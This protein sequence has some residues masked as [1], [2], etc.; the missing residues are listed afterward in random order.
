MTLKPANVGSSS[1][2]DLP[3]D[4]RRFELLQGGLDLIDQGLT[5]FDGDLRLVAWNL[6]FFTLLEFP[7]EMASVGRPFADFMRYNA[8]R[9]EYGDGDVEEK[10]AERVRLARAFQPH[11]MERVRPNGTIVAV[12]GEPLPYGGFVTIYT[13]IT[14]QRYHERLIQERN[15]ELDRRV[16]ERTAA[17]ET[18]NIDL[19]HAMAEQK[20]MQAALVQ[21]Q[22]MEAVGKLTGGLAHDFNNLLTIVIS[23]LAAIRDKGMAG[24]E[25]NDFLEP[26][27]AAARRG[28]DITRRLL[29]FA[30]QQPLEPRSVDVN[31]VV[32]NIL[33]LLRRSLP[34]IV[35]ITSEPG[36]GELH[37][38]ADPSQLENALVNLALNA[39][40]AM[41]KG[42]RLVM[43]TGRR[44]LS[45]TEAAELDVTPG[46]YVAIAVEDTGIGMDQATLS[47]VFEPFFTSKEFGSG[48][49]LGLSMVYGFVRQ[50]GGA[51]RM[52]SEPGKGTT[53]T[54]LL[55]EGVS[56]SD[57]AVEEAQEVLTGAT[58]RHAV[59]LVEDD[60][61]V[62]TVIRRQ[63]VDLGHSVIEASGGKEALAILESVPEVSVLISDIVMPGDI[64]GRRLAERARCRR[65]DI[66]VVLITGYAEGLDGR[67][68]TE[69]VVLRKPCSKEQLA[70]AIHEAGP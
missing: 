29:A 33:T 68:G 64:D 11:Y 60:P 55:R 27:L 21:A 49:G 3:D 25:L 58:A 15:E 46:P 63:L 7:L 31:R 69:T 40:D 14:R 13:D 2:P 18:A 17:L 61:D 67:R 42:G 70:A 53:V 30:R 35:T 12:R 4:R 26:A 43:R 59:L 57:T 51:I 62:R 23:N 16:R 41:P 38:V 34:E 5:V 37:T 19:K 22:K 36:V 39:R 32:A 50:S 45:A 54:L 48:S 56:T 66:R 9:G 10:V 44:E 65:P 28:A 24:P 47:R 20:R 1:S 6:R 8:L 52:R